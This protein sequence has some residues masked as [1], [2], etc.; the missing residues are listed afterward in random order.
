MLHVGE[1][2]NLSAVSVVE[3]NSCLSQFVERRPGLQ[4]DYLEG[5]LQIFQPAERVGRGLA[6]LCATSDFQ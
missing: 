5:R 2:G 6:F 1:T 4:I 3:K